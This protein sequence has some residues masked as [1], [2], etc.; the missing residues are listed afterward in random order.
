MRPLFIGLALVSFPALAQVT[1]TAIRDPVSKSYRQIVRGMEVFEQKKALA[2]QAELR[3]KLLPRKKETRMDQVQVDVVGDSFTLPVDVAPDRTFTLPRDAKA[4]QEDASVRPNRRSQTMTW[5][6]E[7]R[8]PGVPAGMRRLG[9][10]RLEC[11][12]GMAAEL[13][14]NRTKIQKWLDS[15]SGL[16]NYCQRT[17]DNYYLFFADRPLF[18]VTL[19]SGDRRLPLPVERLYNGMSDHPTVKSELPNCDCEVLVD[20]TFDLPLGDKSWPDDTLVEFEY[21]DDAKPVEHASSKEQIRAVLG[22]PT[23]VPFLSGYE[24]WVYRTKEEAKNLPPVTS[25]YAVAFDPAGKAIRTRGLVPAVTPA[26]PPS[27][28]PAARLPDPAPSAAPPRTASD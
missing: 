11:E 7:I 9:D 5:R 4:L 2:P 6:A 17:T 1:V 3:F 12:V 8:S 24:V 28:S 26:T 18:G 21:L 25:T 15:M 19:V 14:S 22:S 13:V 10:L 23:V 27:P 16:Q 20:R